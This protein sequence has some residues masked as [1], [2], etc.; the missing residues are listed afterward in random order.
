MR[1]FIWFDFAYTTHYTVAYMPSGSK[2]WASPRQRVLWINP[3]A[4]LSFPLIT[5][6]TVG[7]EPMIPGTGT[8][9]SNHSAFRL[10][11]LSETIWSLHNWARMII[12][13][14]FS[15]M[16][17]LSGSSVFVCDRAGYRLGTYQLLFF[18]LVLVFVCLKNDIM[19]E[20]ECACVWQCRQQIG[21]LPT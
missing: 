21:D 3:A 18:I 16:T 13:K 19:F 8:K 10:G 2:H 7:S 17:M 1:F 4:N 15:R 5:P 11:N 9:C 20:C 14:K 12:C 6:E